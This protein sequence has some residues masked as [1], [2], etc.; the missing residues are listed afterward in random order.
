[1]KRFLNALRA[2]KS[3]D[4]ADDYIDY[5]G[6]RLPPPRRRFCTEEWKDDGFY[7]AS[8]RKEVERL[9]RVAGLREDSTLLDIGCGQGRLAIGV[10]LALPALRQ[11]IGVDVSLRSVEWCKRHIAAFE[12]RMKF[13]YTDMHNARYNPHGVEFR[14]P[15]Q[16]PLANSSVDVVFLYSVFTHMTADDVRAYLV[17][18]RRLLRPQGRA[19]FTVYAEQNCPDI[20]ENPAG[21]LA[22]LGESSGALHRVRFRQSYFEQLLAEAGLR[23]V[24]FD[25]RCEAP[26][27]QSLY[28]VSPA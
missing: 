3:Q 6:V 2:P 22:E 7:V 16:L 15:I 5:Q 13:I 1:M 24:S 8:A 9:V 17:E 18:I 27:L 11:Y 26:T 19:V 21:Y 14:P 28:V 23:P 10:R 25:Y 12:P 20:E 4:G